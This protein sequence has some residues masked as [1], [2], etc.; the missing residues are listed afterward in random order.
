M[1]ISD[2]MCP[3]IIAAKS[4]RKTQVIICPVIL[5][6]VYQKKSFRFLGSCLLGRCFTAQGA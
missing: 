2:F 3:V 4:E 5:N 6:I 1:R